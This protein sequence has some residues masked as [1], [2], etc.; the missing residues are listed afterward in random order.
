MRKNMN[1][2]WFGASKLNHLI[3]ICYRFPVLKPVRAEVPNLKGIPVWDHQSEYH[4]K[5][6]E[7]TVLDE[8]LWFK[9]SSWENSIG[10]RS[11]ATKRKAEKKMNFSNQWTAEEI[12]TRNEKNSRLLCKTDFF[13]NEKKFGLSWNF[14]KSCRW[15]STNLRPLF[16]AVFQPF[17]PL[18]LRFEHR[19]TALLE[20]TNEAFEIWAGRP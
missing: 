15:M 14:L 17:H 18:K 8:Y 9:K 1:L 4:Q 16:N 7:S 2:R 10:A 6:A 19:K 20:K 11:Y 12:P 13:R 5:H 3:L